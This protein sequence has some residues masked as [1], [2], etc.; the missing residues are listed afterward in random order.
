MN[1][2]RAGLIA[3]VGIAAW[4][5]HYRDPSIDLLE[6]ELRWMEDQLYALEDQL[7]RKTA[8]LDACRQLDCICEDALYVPPAT[9]D[10]QPSRTIT[11]Q[12]AER[13][14]PR[15]TPVD[16]PPQLRS[17]PQNGGA[18]TPGPANGDYE[19]V[20]P[21]VELPEPVTQPEPQLL[22]PPDLD[23]L[24][25]QP[26]E[27]APNSDGTG[28]S[29]G[30]GE[31]GIRLRSYEELVNTA[32]SDQLD[33][34]DPHVTHITLRGRAAQGFDF[35]DQPTAADLLVVVEPRNAEGRYVQLP[36][37]LSLVALDGSQQGPAARIARWDFDA[38][39]TRRMLR[40]SEMGRGIHLPLNWPATAP[41]SDQLVLF[42][43]YETVDGRRLEADT[44][45]Q[46]R[47]L[48]PRNGQW[49]VLQRPEPSP[50]VEARGNGSGTPELL[51]VTS[52]IKLSPIPEQQRTEAF[53][54]N[55]NPAAQIPQVEMP[56][57]R[58]SGGRPEWKPYR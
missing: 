18:K 22:E 11:P 35:D 6:G 56:V 47:D 28:A 13:P 46:V 39:Q 41:D 57:L 58:K 21:T 55:P 7:Q 24:E 54:A 3:L 27:P 31:T 23:A 40:S 20:E 1:C 25:P 16:R 49:R 12:P 48:P 29:S 44:P 17:A 50:P 33:A 9:T 52:P 32:P 10:S 37:R 26:A 42:A 51:P 15:P 34:F 38:D 36:G 14:K 5:C 30:L 45:L 53:G 43:R 4:G 2:L 19:I 8:E